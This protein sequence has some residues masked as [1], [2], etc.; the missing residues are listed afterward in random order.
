MSGLISSSLVAD[1]GDRHK[2]VAV[3]SQCF[4]ASVAKACAEVTEVL[5][6]SLLAHSTCV[7]MAP[8]AAASWIAAG[9]YTVKYYSSLNKGN[10]LLLNSAYLIFSNLPSSD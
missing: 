4:L 5:V 2:P 8:N 3:V 7:V 1:L 6:F 9:F 10:K